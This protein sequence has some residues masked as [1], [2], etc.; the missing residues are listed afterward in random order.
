MTDDHESTTEEGSAEENGQTNHKKP[1]TRR[2][3]KTG[4]D[5]V[6]LFAQHFGNSQEEGVGDRDGGRPKRKLKEI[7]R[8]D[9]ESYDV[10]TTCKTG[11]GFPCP[12]CSFVCSYDSRSC[13]SC[14]LPCYYEAGQGVVTLKERNDMNAS[15]RT[16]SK[17]SA[18][19]TKSKKTAITKAMSRAKTKQP[20][21]ALKLPRSTSCDTT[22]SSIE[23]VVVLFQQRQFV[24]KDYPT[25]AEARKATKASS[26]TVLDS[27]CCI[28]CLR[29]L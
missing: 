9:P 15:P 27:E 4:R 8:F 24:I 13:T 17:D 5:D 23:G 26:G 19:K 21:L 1:T 7:S 12:R 14:L 28:A 29:F 11:E 25:I 16:Q 18:R 6:Q 10:Q 22:R 3:K 20:T 2:P